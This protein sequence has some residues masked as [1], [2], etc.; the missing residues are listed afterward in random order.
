MKTNTE[1]QTPWA[2]MRHHA[3]WGDVFYIE[4]ETADAVTGI[5]PEREDHDPSVWYS[6]RALLAR[7]ETCEDARAAREGAIAEWRTHEARV[8]EAQDALKQA[9]LARENAWLA[10]LRAGSA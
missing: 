8:R 9:E 5:Y 3:G 1:I 10:C 4:A 2:L 6:R 7:F